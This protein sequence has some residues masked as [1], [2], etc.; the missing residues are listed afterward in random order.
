MVPSTVSPPSTNSGSFVS[1]TFDPYAPTLRPGTNGVLPP[2]GG[3]VTTPVLPG[4]AYP[5][6]VYP[7]TIYPGTAYPG[8]VYPNTIYPN[9]APPAL[10][11]GGLGGSTPLGSSTYGNSGWGMPSAPTPSTYGTPI[12]GNGW[13]SGNLFGNGQLGT[14]WFNSNPNGPLWQGPSTTPIRFF[15]GPRF[16]HTWL[17]S[18][19]DADGLGIND[20]EVS[21]VFAIPSFLSSSNPLYVIPSFA[22]HLWE[23]P[24]NGVADLPGQAY[25]A[26]LDTGWESDPMRTFG[27]DLGARVGI[28]SDFNTINSESLRVL[29]KALGRVR[30]TPNT[31]FRLGVYWINR[32]RYKLVPGGGILWT[33]NPDSRFDISFPEPKLAHYVTTFGNTDVWWYL[34]GYYGGGTWTI[35][36]T[37]GASDRVDINDI[38][39]LL[40][41]EFGRND[42]IRQ[43]RRTGFIEAG[44][45][46]NREIIYRRNPGDNLDD[47]PDAFVLRAGIGY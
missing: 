38:R 30:L 23:G 13:N 10:F 7:G 27:V 35:E 37:S 36:R 43:G 19:N 21:L 46:F 24:A 45:A 39:V 33:P 9:Q 20:S 44:Y 5:G 3:F 6:S 14:G 18:S 40:G 15:Q 29:A 12:F 25:S 32:N 11:P 2:S 8:S 28:F 22:I 31:T 26:F 16:R 41:L 47:I 17:T 4:Q 42:L 1:P 34:T